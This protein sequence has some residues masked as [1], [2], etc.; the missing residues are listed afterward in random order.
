MNK[1]VDREW[2]KLPETQKAVYEKLA[3]KQN[4]LKA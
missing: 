2:G 1:I 3:V 4:A